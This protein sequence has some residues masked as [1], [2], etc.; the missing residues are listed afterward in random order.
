[1]IK[2]EIRRI[3]NI[4]FEPGCETDVKIKA[5]IKKA[6]LITLQAEKIDYVCEVNIR[7]TDNSN[8][9][10]LNKNF[11]GKDTETDVLSFVMGDIN[12]ENGAV[13]LGD[14]VISIEKA[15]EQSEELNQSLDMELM[16]LAVHAALHLIGYDHEK[17]EEED[18]IMRQRQ[19]EIMEMIL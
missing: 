15:K 6:V 8:I 9:R 12:P 4:D 11:R 1:M 13:I 5:K 17:S 10:N 16:F 7:I 2:K 3:I 14:I 18:L 19:K